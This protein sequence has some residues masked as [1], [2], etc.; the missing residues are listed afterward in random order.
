[1]QID[2][3]FD[4]FKALTARRKT[5]SMT[6]NDVI[7]ELL[8]LDSSAR[9]ALRVN[10]ERAEA[11][12]ALRGFAGYSHRGLSLP[13]GTQ[14]RA[15][16]KG[17]VYRAEIRDGKWLDDTGVE[18]LSPSGAAHAITGTNVNGL[19]FWEAQRPAD[20]EWRKLDA[21]PKAALI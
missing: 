1:M 7:R 12:G 15:T 6:Y 19:R 18:H 5:E 17:Q 4:V 10:V 16:Y 8:G 20:L 13:D 14:L 11:R 3:D 9:S 21:L 2:I